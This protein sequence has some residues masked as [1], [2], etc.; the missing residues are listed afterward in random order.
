MAITLTHSVEYLQNVLTDIYQHY[1]DRTPDA[2]GLHYWVQTMQSGTTDQQVEASFLGSREYIA[3]HG[4]TGA[5]WVQGMYHDLLG[6]NPDFVG[7]G[8][9]FGC[10]AFRCESVDDFSQ[11]LRRAL[12]LDV[13]SL[14]VVPIDYSL[15]VG[16]SEE[17]G[18]ETVAA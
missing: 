5:A 9:S 10:A 15:D 11:H 12:D 4:G 6:R 16:I 1:L 13:P 17:L 18:R 14:I 2:P 3:D 8:E 7:L